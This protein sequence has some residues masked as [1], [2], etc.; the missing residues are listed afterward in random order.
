MLILNVLNVLNVLRVLHVPNVL[1]ALNS[2]VSRLLHGTLGTVLVSS[3]SI[4]IRCAV[5]VSIVIVLPEAVPP[6][7]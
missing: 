3:L 5:P 4:V 2:P 1:N 7:H 6:V